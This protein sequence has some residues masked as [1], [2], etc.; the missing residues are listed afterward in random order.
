MNRRGMAL[1]VVLWMLAALTVVTGV[2]LAGVRL[3]A[4]VSVNRKLLAKAAW[5]AE[6]CV[7][8]Y[9]SDASD[10][11][12]EGRSVPHGRFP[13]VEL[14]PGIWCQLEVEDPHSKVNANSASLEAL[15]AA[16]EDTALVQLVLNGRPWPAVEAIATSPALSELQRSLLSALLTVRGDGR[17]NL[18]GADARVLRAVPGIST[19]A[20]VRIA[21]GRTTGQVFLST[22]E[23]LAVLAPGDRR[24]VLARYSDF[25][26]VATTQPT[27][28]VARA[29]GAAGAPALLTTMTVTLVP[30]G[31]RVAIVRWESE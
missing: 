10:S 29:T 15:E 30:A 17:I 3:G 26:H 6:A 13:R 31:N 1:L 14:G 22:D 7:A 23:V 20:S 12:G 16:L 21:Q 8:I 27:V 9:R 5:A 19:D 2:A 4:R 11:L 28:L 18:N 25:I 24:A